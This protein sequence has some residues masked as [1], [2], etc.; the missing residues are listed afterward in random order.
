MIPKVKIFP[1]SCS[2]E[3][4]P[5][6]RPVFAWEFAEEFVGE[7]AAYLPNSRSMFSDRASHSETLSRLKLEEIQK[8][9]RFWGPEVI[10]QILKFRRDPEVLS[11][12]WSS[13]VLSKHWNPK[14]HSRSPRI[15]TGRS[16]A[17]TDFRWSAWP[18]GRR[19]VRGR[20]ECHSLAPDYSFVQRLVM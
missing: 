16:G 20:F 3:S 9:A 8:F 18:S 1:A 19:S 13:E 10:P 15:W 4:W 17:E 11:K 2:M 14:V 7:F 12:F 5:R 6:V